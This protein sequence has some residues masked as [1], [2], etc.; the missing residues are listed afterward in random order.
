MEIG[1]SLGSILGHLR[2]MDRIVA[3]CSRPGTST[4]AAKLASLG[5]ACPVDVASL[6]GLIDGFDTPLNATIGEIALFPGYYMLSI[7]EAVE[8]YRSIYDSGQWNRRW[9]PIFASGG[10]DFYAVICDQSSSDFGAVVG[11]LSGEPD[12]IVEFASISAMLET[13]SVAYTE[14]AF[15]L[16][17]GNLEADFPKMRRIAQQVQPDFAEH[18]A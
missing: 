5:L 2:S 9:F 17:E 4:V 12:H 3:D 8:S 1:A 11:F 18:D 7:E 14:G 6:Y 16:A 10:G 13:I 15:Y